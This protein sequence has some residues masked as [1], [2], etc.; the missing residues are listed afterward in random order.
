[1]DKLAISTP[2]VQ[3]ISVISDT[4]RNEIWCS[5]YPLS[6]PDMPPRP[7]ATSMDQKGV[8]SLNDAVTCISISL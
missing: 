6:Y 4:S 1:M 5:H 7:P 2:D 8:G 3:K